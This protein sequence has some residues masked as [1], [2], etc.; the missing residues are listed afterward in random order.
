MKEDIVRLIEE[1]RSLS[2]SEW[3]WVKT[4]LLNSD[5]KECDN[6]E[7]KVYRL[8]RKL[9]IPSDIKGFGYIK[10]A[11]MLC[12]EDDKMCKSKAG[13]SKLYEKI[14]IEYDT[15]SNKIAGTIAHAIEVSCKR[16]DPDM[17]DEVFGNAFSKKTGR[18]SNSDFIAGIVDYIQL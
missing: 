18:P 8:L 12:L 10:R 2:Y 14:A 7:K 6:I 16:G 5:D 1:L 9:G 3:E 15:T 17:L 4:L 13:V 11:V